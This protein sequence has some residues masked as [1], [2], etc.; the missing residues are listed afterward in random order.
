MKNKTFGDC[1]WMYEEEKI[2]RLPAGIFSVGVGQHLVEQ[3]GVPAHVIV[4]SLD[5]VLDKLIDGGANIGAVNQTKCYYRRRGK[6]IEV[7]T[8]QDFEEL[9]WGGLCDICDKHAK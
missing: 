1:A 4:D 2:D 7:G 8:R 6:A 9:G 3:S 5:Q